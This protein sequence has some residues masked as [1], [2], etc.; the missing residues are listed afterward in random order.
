MAEATFGQTA[1]PFA[2]SLAY[3]AYLV[4]AS[5]NIAVPIVMPIVMLLCFL[6]I[7][8]KRAE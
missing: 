1:F 4:Q 7:A 6:G 2:V 3:L 8:G 5:I